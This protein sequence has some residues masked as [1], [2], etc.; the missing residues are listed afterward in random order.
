MR[1]ILEGGCIWHG[2]KEEVGYVLSVHFCRLKRL[3]SQSGTLEKLQ[4]Q[5][6]HWSTVSDRKYVVFPVVCCLYLLHQG[7]HLMIFYGVGMHG[8]TT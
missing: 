3:H 8:G 4:P 5:L 7:S 1:C 2:E 6:S